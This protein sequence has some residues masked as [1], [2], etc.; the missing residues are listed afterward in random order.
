MARTL[1]LTQFTGRALSGML[2]AE[3][4]RSRNTELLAAVARASSADAFSV[5]ADLYRYNKYTR[6]V[7]GEIIARSRALLSQLKRAR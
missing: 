5:I 6:S 7:P 2:A 4:L 1:F 3:P